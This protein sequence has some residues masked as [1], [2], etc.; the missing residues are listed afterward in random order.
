MP[1]DKNREEKKEATPQ[2]MPQMSPVEMEMLGVLTVGPRHPK[3]IETIQ[4]YLKTLPDT[5]ELTE[6]IHLKDE[7]RMR[8]FLDSGGRAKGGAITRTLEEH[9]RTQLL[10]KIHKTNDNAKQYIEDLQN[11]M[12]SMP[13]KSEAPE[14]AEMQ[15][16]VAIGMFA[17]RA[18]IEAKS[19][20]MFG[21]SLDQKRTYKE[22]G[23]RRELTNNEAVKGFFDKLGYEKTRTLI[24]TGHGGEMEKAFQIYVAKRREPLPENLPKRLMPSAKLRI[25]GLQ[26]QL[27]AATTVEKKAELLKEIVATRRMVG[28]ERGGKNLDQKV[29]VAGMEIAHRQIKQV[30]G[31]DLFKDI[32]KDPKMIEKALDGHGGA[33]LDSVEAKHEAAMKKEE[34]A[35]VLR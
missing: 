7:L 4:K 8:L 32:A 29:S 15:K 28:A 18:G 1:D 6:G 23:A 10:D 27:R 33:F 22:D 25:E 3:Y 14:D 31:D 13:K 17:A 11:V 24:L 26:D 2:P 20:S 19:G 12:K 30:Y 5:N 35:F 9:E 16:S 21:R 34:S